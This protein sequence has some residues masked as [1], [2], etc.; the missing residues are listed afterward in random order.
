M[1]TIRLGVQC[2]E[3]APRAL[4]AASFLL[5]C[6][7]QHQQEEDCGPRSEPGLSP[8]PR[9]PQEKHG[10]WEVAEVPSSQTHL[11]PSS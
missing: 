3:E 6:R 9:A 1:D 10:G 11:P 8:R 5:L 4:P 2:A 7:A